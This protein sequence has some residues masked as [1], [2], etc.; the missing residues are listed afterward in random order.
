MVTPRVA[1]FGGDGRHAARCP[2]EWTVYASSGFGGNGPKRRLVAAIK[3]GNVDIVIIL[4]KWNGHSDIHAITAAC[5]ST[6][7]RTVVTW[8]NPAA[9]A[10]SSNAG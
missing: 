10:Q 1:V 2:S 8:T 3:A 5:R 6:G 7:V 4:A 9:L